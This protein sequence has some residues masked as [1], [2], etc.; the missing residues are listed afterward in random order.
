MPGFSSK[1]QTLVFTD[2]ETR[3]VVYLKGTNT[4]SELVFTTDRVDCG[5]ID[6]PLPGGQFAS[7]FAFTYTPFGGIQEAGAPDPA[8][9]ERLE[10]LRHLT[11]F[12]LGIRVNI[13]L[14]IHEMRKDFPAKTSQAAAYLGEKFIHY[15]KLSNTEERLMSLRMRKF[16]HR[17]KRQA[18]KAR[19][20]AE[21]DAIYLH[22]TQ[23][24][25]LGTFSGL[26]QQRKDKEDVH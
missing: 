2:R 6:A 26:Y 20:A 17:L 1:V 10:L 22:I 14:A 18:A 15:W 11:R 12:L 4:P 8:T 9:L 16:F 3:R 25:S 5:V 23:N 24:V 13:A 7:P 21:I 19:S